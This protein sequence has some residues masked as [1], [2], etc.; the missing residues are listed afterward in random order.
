MSKPPSIITIALIAHGEDKPS[1]SFN[2]ANVRILSYAGRSGCIAW[3]DAQTLG[4]INDEFKKYYLEYRRNL[5]ESGLKRGK[6]YSDFP[7][8]NVC[9]NTPN[10]SF[11]DD[12]SVVP[13]SS[14]NFL[15]ND[16]LREIKD[17]EGGV[18]IDPD[19]FS[20]SKGVYNHH[21][22]EMLQDRSR[23]RRLA[24]AE[25]YTMEDSES[26]LT[27][28]IY[29]PVIDKLYIFKDERD[30]D[31][32]DR[33]HFGIYVMDI[34]NYDKKV[35]GNVNIKVD[36]NLLSKKGF[37]K[38]FFNHVKESKREI[39]LECIS[40]YLHA[41]GFEIINIIDVSC[42]VYSSAEFPLQ[43]PRPMHID[44][45]TLSITPEKYNRYATSLK[46]DLETRYKLNKLVGGKSRKK[47]TRS[48]ILNK[49]KYIRSNKLTR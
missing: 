30:P 15:K 44:P 19:L 25:L 46:E 22:I 24:N 28:R 41:I 23:H 42:R 10:F 33:L 3:S 4:N 26:S 20:F 34:C 14:Y 38:K 6:L 8:A 39:T 16:F 5:S 13:V 18:E 17:E 29:T 40:T 35:E 7:D 32:P 12:G 31:T 45:T 36:D 9:E 11:K 37:N 21:S 1:D 2:D 43:P 48:K 47:K 49:K 27:H